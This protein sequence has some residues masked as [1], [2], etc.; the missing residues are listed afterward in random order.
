MSVFGTYEWF[1]MAKAKDARKEWKSGALY[2]SEHK[3]NFS[4]RVTI[5]ILCALISIY[6]GFHVPYGDTDLEQVKHV[7]IFHK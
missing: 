5:F 2:F 3:Q 7:F 4:V 6:C 1:V